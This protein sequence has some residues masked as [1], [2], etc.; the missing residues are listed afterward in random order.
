MI[1]SSNAELRALDLAHVW[2]PCTQMKDHEATMPLVPIHH[3]QG[4]WLEDFGKPCAQRR[5]EVLALERKP[6]DRL[7]V[8]Q[9]VSGV[10]AGPTERHA[11]DPARQRE[12]AQRVGEL[13][14]SPASGSGA[15]EDGE[16][17]RIEDVATDDRE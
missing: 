13:D 3:G 6:D 1:H 8:G 2:H 14:L 15:R 7:E 5:A 17:L 9:P 12:L 4:A 10:V 11:V 16:D